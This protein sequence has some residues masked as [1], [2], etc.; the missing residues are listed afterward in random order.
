MNRMKPHINKDCLNKVFVPCLLAMAE[1]PV[2]NIRFN[3]S[4]SVQDFYKDMTPGS[5]KQ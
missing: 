1:D 5:K 2:P 3:I 4:K